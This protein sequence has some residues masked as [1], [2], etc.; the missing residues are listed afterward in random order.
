MKRSSQV[1]P[2]PWSKGRRFGIDVGR[3][4]SGFARDGDYQLDT[5]PPG[6]A[7]RFMIAGT[8]VWGSAAAILRR[9]GKVKESVDKMNFG[10]KP[11]R[12][13]REKL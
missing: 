13:Q 1:N 10:R 4:A 8:R 3:A 5:K 12:H 9:D 11:K 6:A 7:Q 2:S